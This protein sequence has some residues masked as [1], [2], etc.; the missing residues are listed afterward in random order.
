MSAV[1]LRRLSVLGVFGMHGLTPHGATPG[2]GAH[3][4]A[5]T[6]TTDEPTDPSAVHQAAGHHRMLGGSDTGEPASG[7]RL[8]AVK[9]FVVTAIDGQ[10]LTPRGQGGSPAHM[11][12]L[13]AAMLLVAAASALLALRMRRLALATLTR[14]KPLAHTVA[15]RP[16][17][18]AW[19]GP[20]PV[21]EF[22][23]I[24]C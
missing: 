19:T 17:G 4:S 15:T 5:P 22:S 23:V 9:S 18:R 13:C 8:T 3:Q 16:A 11:G 7:H 21:L 12:D 20:P 6:T 1:G 2:H 14:L 24:R 10:A